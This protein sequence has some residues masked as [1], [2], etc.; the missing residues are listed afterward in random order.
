MHVNSDVNSERSQLLH[1]N[2]IGLQ[3]CNGTALLVPRC[4]NQLDSFCYRGRVHIRE[5]CIQM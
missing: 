3:G 1:V 2:P 4:Y 5:L